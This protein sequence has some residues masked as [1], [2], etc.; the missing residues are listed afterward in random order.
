VLLRLYH[1]NLIAM[2]M[3]MMMTLYGILF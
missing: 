2:M 1:V 3:M